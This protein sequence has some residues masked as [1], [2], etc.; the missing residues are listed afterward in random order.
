MMPLAVTTYVVS[1]VSGHC[2]VGRLCGFFP[3]C[4]LSRLSLPRCDCIYWKTRAIAP[5]ISLLWTC[6]K[7]VVSLIMNS[8]QL[9]LHFI[10]RDMIVL[11][12]RRLKL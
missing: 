8:C 2:S 4:S 10:C 9:K 6:G 7:Q 1:I 5:L 3:L 11:F 12:A